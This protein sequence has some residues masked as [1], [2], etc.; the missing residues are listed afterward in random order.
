MWT[1][2]FSHLFF[3]FEKGSPMSLGNRPQ[4][5]RLG[6][7]PVLYF[8]PILLSPQLVLYFT[9]EL[10][11]L[12]ERR[13]AWAPVLE[14]YLRRSN[15]C[16]QMPAAE[17]PSPRSHGGRTGAG[18]ALSLTPWA[19]RRRRALLLLGRRPSEAPLYADPPPASGQPEPGRSR[20]RGA[21]EWRARRDGKG[22]RAG[23]SESIWR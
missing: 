15:K 20:G 17:P 5:D 2:G 16:A 3:F 13:P 8:R 19:H 23:F 14:I 11:R 4:F 7:R 6:P 18:A 10:G 1:P 21:G 22:R 9:P 12:V